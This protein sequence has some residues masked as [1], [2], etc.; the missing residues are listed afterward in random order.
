MEHEDTE[1]QHEARKAEEEKEYDRHLEQQR[2]EGL[3]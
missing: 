1:R 2:E 3:I